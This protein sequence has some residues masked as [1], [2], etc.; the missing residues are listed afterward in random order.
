M[1]GGAPEGGG[2]GREERC[3]E[4]PCAS[5]ALLTALL[6]GTEDAKV[7]G[8]WRSTWMRPKKDEV[9]MLRIPL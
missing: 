3:K 6:T 7:L 2:G 1:T 5:G 9:A 8:R 4:A